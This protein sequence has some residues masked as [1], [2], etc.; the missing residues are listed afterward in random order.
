MASVPLRRLRA[1]TYASP[2]SPAMRALFLV[3]AA[4]SFA[5][6]DSSDQ[7]NDLVV[8]PTRHVVSGPDGYSVAAAALEY[9]K[10]APPGSAAAAAVEDLGYAH[11]GSEIHS[12]SSPS[13][14][15]RVEVL[16]PEKLRRAP[17]WAIGRTAREH[18][19]GGHDVDVPTPSVA[20][21]ISVDGL[22]LPAH[23]ADE[24]G[25]AYE[26]RSENRIGVKA[27][28]CRGD[29][30]YIVAADGPDDDS[31]RAKALYTD[32]LTETIIES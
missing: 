1:E 12:F 20:R 27:Y 30:C 11:P 4:L 10:H 3:A 29:L 18:W 9:P 14:D 21:Q 17:I 5:A 22:N 32:L 31:D 26:V 8:V 28:G 23:L 13:S 6:C 15:L 7:P 2:L 25:A 24:I 16:F 19:L